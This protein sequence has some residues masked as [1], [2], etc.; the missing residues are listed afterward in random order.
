MLKS[1]S[2][3]CLLANVN[4]LPFTAA[5]FSL[6]IPF[7]IHLNNYRKLLANVNC[8]YPLLL[9]ISRETDLTFLKGIRLTGRH[10]QPYHLGNFLFT[11][12]KRPGG[13][14]LVY[15]KKGETMTWQEINF[16]FRLT[17]T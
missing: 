15:S 6:D 1:Y 3:T 2:I 13:W 14:W 17:C 8:F 4:C 10:L 11:S 9:L 16:L 12:L 7:K 5:H